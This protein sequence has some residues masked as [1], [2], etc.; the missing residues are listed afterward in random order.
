MCYSFM[1]YFVAIENA[2]QLALH[3]LY[4]LIH[5]VTLDSHL[6]LQCLEPYLIIGTV[7]L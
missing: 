3:S 5:H 6:H 1:L 2:F 4:L 7:Y